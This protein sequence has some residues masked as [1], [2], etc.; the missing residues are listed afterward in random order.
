MRTLFHLFAICFFSI[1][2]AQKHDNI[3][4]GGYQAYAEPGEA[5]RLNFNFSSGR[6]QID[7]LTRKMELSLTQ[8]SICDSSGQIQFMAN[9][10]WV[11]DRF[12]NLMQNGSNI[13]MGITLTCPQ[14]ARGFQ[15]GISLPR[16]GWLNQ[17]YLI[18]KQ[19]KNTQLEFSTQIKYSEINVTLNGGKGEVVI[20]NQLIETDTSH[21]TQLAACKHANG[22]DWWI[23]LTPPDFSNHYSMLL[24]D[25]TGIQLHHTQDIGGQ[26]TFKT[27][28]GKSLMQTCF[29]PD[30]S[31]YVRGSTWDGTRV[32]DFDRCTGKLSNEKMV[33]VPFF[34]L[35]SGIGVCISPNNR[36]L[37]LA[38]VVE[39][40]QVD[41]WS[42]NI[43]S[44]RIRIDTIDGH[45][46]TLNIPMTFLF[47]TN[48]PDGKIYVSDGNASFKWHTIHQPNKYGQ[49]C[50]FRQ[51]DLSMPTPNYNGVNWHYADIWYQGHYTAPHFRLG[52]IDG[53]SCDTLGFDNHPLCNWRWD[54]YDTL[55]QKQ[56]TFTDNSTYEPQ[57]WL[58]NFGDGTT[59]QDTSP[60]HTY[61][62]D[63]V[64]NV[65]LIVCNQYSCDTLCQLVTIGG[66]AVSEP[67][68]LEELFIRPNPASES[69]TISL[70]EFNETGHFQLNLTNLL[71]QQL[72]AKPFT[73]S[74]TTIDV[75]QLPSG[76]VFIQVI[77][78]GQVRAVG[79]AVIM[80]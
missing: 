71:G 78:N 46:A 66:V 73:A 20:K 76:P 14:G 61:L 44:S 50:H 53:S 18:Y 43:Q 21:I 64:Y 3:W 74:Q 60:V 2:H 55:N 26:D 19:G 37:Y 67:K 57:T 58:W 52:P 80:R 4:P 12:G 72:L 75:S 28:L 56:I 30:G 45:K 35:S 42:Q 17:Y 68:A 47:M 27:N 49:A 40:F 13:G 65:C 77:E 5:N 11:A 34:E 29:S 1:L 54:F 79:R 10:C 48:G 69:L 38:N 39:L 36:F 8:T 32:F 63:G 9:G 15:G 31:K 33:W 51:H 23:I 62:T 7:T 24:V 16:P 59:S 41:L 6:L 25:P 22:R 70:S